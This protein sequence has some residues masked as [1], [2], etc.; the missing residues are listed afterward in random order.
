MNPNIVHETYYTER[1]IGRAPR[2][3]VAVYDMIHELF[4][5]DLR[6]AAKVTAAKRASVMRADHVIC[7]SE[8]TRQDLIGLFGLEQERTSVCILAPH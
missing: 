3:V 4:P 8:R 5:G 6:D 2:R 7:I 1:P